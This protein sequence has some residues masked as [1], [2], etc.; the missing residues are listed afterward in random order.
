MLEVRG[1]PILRNTIEQCKLYGITELF[2]NT[3][4]LA[5]Q[6]RNTFGDG[7]AFGVNIEY[8]FEPELLGT[9]GALKNFKTHLQ[10]EPFFV[11]Y[12]DNYIPYDLAQIYQYHLRKNGIA[13]IVLYH[14][15]DV[16]LSGIAVLDEDDAI[17]RFIEKPKP[18]ET[19]SHL[20]NTGVYVCSPEIFKFI[21]EGFSDFGKDIF[22]KMI[23]GGEKLYGCVMQENMLAVDTWE[24]YQK[25]QKLDVVA[26]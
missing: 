19:V 12:G 4:H 18:E 13:T 16:S 26:E 6:I 11:I 5:E 1:K 24:L 21:D 7:S 17:L 25:A 14:L 8:S 15:D 23:A 22:P 2:I 3:H 10:D 20:V 9:A